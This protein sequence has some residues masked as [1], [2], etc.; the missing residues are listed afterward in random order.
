MLQGNFP[1][2]TGSIS[3]Q[4]NLPSQTGSIQ[5]EGRYRRKRVPPE[6]AG[7]IPEKEGKVGP[8]PKRSQD[9]S[10]RRVAGNDTRKLDGKID[11]LSKTLSRTCYMLYAI[12]NMF[13]ILLD[14]ISNTHNVA[15]TGNEEISEI[16]AV[17]EALT[18]WC[19]G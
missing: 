14:Q 1:S 7:M 10:P 12:C 3:A 17:S 8:A 2:Q 15:L 19:S 18:P 5:P 4:G 6:K 16:V 9:V 13:E 11:R